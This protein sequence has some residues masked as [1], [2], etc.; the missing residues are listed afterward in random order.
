[1]IGDVQHREVV[2]DER[3]R[4]AHEC[5]CDEREEKA[6]R[7]PRHRHPFEI[8]ARCAHHRHDREHQRDAQR[9]PE[10][11]VAEFRNHYRTS[12]ADDPAGTTTVSASFSC[13][14]VCARFNASAASGGM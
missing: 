7:R 1:M 4:E 3:G 2:G 8:A 9:E 5:E 12:F 11:E 10:R 13:L 14:P 6:R